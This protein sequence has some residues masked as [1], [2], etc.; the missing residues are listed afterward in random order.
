MM[1]RPMMG[2]P[3]T[4]AGSQVDP[5]LYRNEWPDNLF[6]MIPFVVPR[7]WDYTD[8]ARRVAAPVL[9][10]HGSN[11]P[12]AAIEGGRAWRDLIPSAQLLEIE[13]VGHAPWLEAPDQ[14][15]KAVDEFLRTG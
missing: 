1:I 8:R 14:F 11:D 10:V 7:E 3:E 15:F 5:C 6:R 13:G 9:I 2:R 4:A 12:N